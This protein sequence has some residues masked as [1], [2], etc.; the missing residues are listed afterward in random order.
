MGSGYDRSDPDLST[1]LSALREGDL[2]A[3]EAIARRLFENAPDDPA[4]HQ[5]AAV[6][7]LQRGEIQRAERS[8]A[9]SLA[10]RPDHVPTLVIAGRAARA[11]ED[12]AG[13]AAFFRRAAILAPNRADA[14]FLACVTL[15]E[16]GDPEA[17][18]LLP[19]LLDQFPDDPEGW[20]LLGATLER[21]DQ[22]EAA[23]LAFTRAA[24]TAPSVALHLRRGVLLESLGR[25][26]DAI[27]AYRAAAEMGPDQP[28]AWLKLGLCL[29]RIGADDAASALERAITLAP[30]SSDAWFAVA[31]VRQD[32]RDFGSAAEAYCRALEIRPKFAEA[33]VNL[34]ICHQEDG[35]MAA[36]KM[37]YQ[38]ALGLQPDTFGRI[39]QALAAAP[40]GEVWLDIA[41]LRGSLTG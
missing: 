5:L 17:G 4:V 26:V 15:L 37:A 41:A 10:R 39:A 23:L 16:L 36:A 19:R 8:A 30:D 29:R 14:A 18:T 3:A 34:G 33:A 21:A 2:D 28:D 20:R 27:G 7:A 32:K 22:S 25:T 11:A 9:A 6:I 38:L 35:D 1:A 40:I 24:H 13:A 12:L 31:L